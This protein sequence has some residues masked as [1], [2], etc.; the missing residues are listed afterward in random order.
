MNRKEIL[1]YANGISIGNFP[2]LKNLGI[3]P[4]I[5]IN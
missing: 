3:F 5:S 4:E 2:I 1:T